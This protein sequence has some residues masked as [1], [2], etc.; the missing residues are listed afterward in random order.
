MP[1]KWKRGAQA[2]ASSATAEKSAI[3]IPFIILFLFFG[4]KR[5]QRYANFRRFWQIFCK[6]KAGSK[7]CLFFLITL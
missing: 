5:A 3:F 7:T 4:E 2:P 1:V 6:K